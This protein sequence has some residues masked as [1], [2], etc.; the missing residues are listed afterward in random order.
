M[1]DPTNGAVGGRHP[2]RIGVARDPKQAIPLQ[3]SY[4]GQASDFIDMTVE[5]K[6]TAVG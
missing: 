5:V 1:V 6:V 3:G 4:R 2:I